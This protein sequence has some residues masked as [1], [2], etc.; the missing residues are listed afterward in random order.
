[1]SAAPDTLWPDCFNAG[2]FVL[3]PSM[4]IYNGLLQMLSTTGSF[5]G[6]EQVSA[7]FLDV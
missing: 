5:D 4:D 7:L 3:K 6:R 2:V 1:M